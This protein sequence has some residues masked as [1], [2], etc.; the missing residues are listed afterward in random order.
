MK[1]TTNVSYAQGPAQR[2][3]NK[4]RL[5]KKD[6]AAGEGLHPETLPRSCVRRHPA[7]D[8][9][10]ETRRKGE[11]HME[12]RGKGLHGGYLPPDRPAAEENQSPG[13]NTFTLK[14]VGGN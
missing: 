1:C 5:V 12:T 13:E 2:A 8:R 9:E 14:G 11:M 3:E 6:V 4:K 10:K 7:R